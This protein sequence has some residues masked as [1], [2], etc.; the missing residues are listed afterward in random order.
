MELRERENSRLLRRRMLN[1]E[2]NN[3]DDMQNIPRKTSM[4]FLVIVCLTAFLGGGALMADPTGGLLGMA[5]D[6]LHASPF[7]DYL[8]PGIF[9]FVVIGFGSLI[10]IIA[11][12][13]RKKYAS[14]LVM[15]CGGVLMAWIAI[16]I[17]M[18][19]E[20]NSF[21]AFYFT[22]GLFLVWLGF[23]QREI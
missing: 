4:V 7:P 1:V 13:G 9:L 11:L 14:T 17:V 22:T 19:D 6:R 21:H 8:I 2:D 16:Q 3:A 15:L 20:I 10:T 23:R 5:V 18:L 12:V